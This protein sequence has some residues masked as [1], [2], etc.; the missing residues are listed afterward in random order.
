[1]STTVSLRVSGI[2][3]RDEDRLDRIEE[4]YP[5]VA[6]V[7]RNGFVIVEIS[8][9]DEDCDLYHEITDVIHRM[10]STVPSLVFQCVSPELVNTSDIARLSGVSRQAVTKWVNH[11]ELGFPQELDSVGGDGRPQKIWSLYAVNDWLWDVLNIDLDL[12]LPPYGLVK[13]LDAFILNPDEP[14]SYE[15]HNLDHMEIRQ[16]TT[17][18][19]S[20]GRRKLSIVTRPTTTKLNQEDAKV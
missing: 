11:E 2:D 19:K 8:V 18:Q 17:V 7:R 13:R 15:W 6:I 3:I 16:Q 9:E 4:S 5:E 12:E 10:R 20:T 14:T 1:M